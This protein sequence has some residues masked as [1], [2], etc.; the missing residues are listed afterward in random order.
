[1]RICC[2][3]AILAA[4]AVSPTMA[5]EADVEKPE[6]LEIRHSQIG[7]RNTLL[8]YTFQKQR[9]IMVLSIGNK[10]ET[11]PITGKVHLFGKET[12][13]KGLKKWINNQH[14]DGLYPDVPQPVSTHKLSP[15]SCKVASR[16]QTGVSRNPGFRGG[17]Y[18]DFEVT[19]SIEAEDIG[20]KFKLP[21]FTDK[22]RVHVEDK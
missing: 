17:M 9:A 20:G 3:L 22:A 11:F 10:D 19:L 8:F 1:M 14:S 15:K 12:T 6:K 4:L 13:E 16:K 5:D 2:L 7:Y 21:A 18:K